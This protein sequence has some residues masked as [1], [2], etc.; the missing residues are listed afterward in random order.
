M[1]TDTTKVDTT[2]VALRALTAYH[3]AA[4]DISEGFERARQVLADTDVT[5]GSFG[6]LQE[7]HGL[8]DRYAERC[9]EG[10]NA[11]RDGRDVFDALAEA[12][13]SIRSAY[14]DADQAAA[15]RFGGGD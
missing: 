4:Q 13:E 15:A 10:L 12:M 9:D 7:A 8:H 2:K 5:A 14:R 1:T 11:L 6:L 3:Q